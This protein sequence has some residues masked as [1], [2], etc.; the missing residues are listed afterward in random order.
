MKKFAA[1]LYLL[2]VTPSFA[3][4][5]VVEA[6]TA[7]QLDGVWSFSVTISHPDTGW[8]HYADGWEVL[9]K[10]GNRL[11][12]RVLAH[13][14]TQEQPFNRTLG[15]VEVPQGIQVVFIRTRCIVDGWSEESREFSLTN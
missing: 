13:P 10:E 4:A 3:D 6:V 1:C 12:L 5:P 15:G 11:G 14:H 8:D 9:D 7:Q 2:F